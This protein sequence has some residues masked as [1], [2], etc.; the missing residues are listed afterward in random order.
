VLFGP[1]GYLYAGTGDG[2]SGNDP[3]AN[4]QNINVL[5]GKIIRLDIN[6]PVGQV[7]AYNIPPTNPY[8]G[9]TPGADEIFAIG[10]RNPYRFSFDRG[11][12]NQ[13]WVGDVGQDAV[14]E[15]DI[16][17]VGGNYGWRVYEGNQCTGIEPTNCI[18]SNYLPPVLTYA[19]AG[20]RCSV[21]GG[22]VYRGTLKTFADGTYIHSDFCS[23]EIFTWINNTH[24]MRLD[25]PRLASSFGED[26]RGEIYMTGL[27]GTNPPTGTVEKVVRVR[28]NSDF[29]GDLRTDVSVYRPS[30]GNWYITNSNN[31]SVRIQSFGL[32]GDI[33]ANEDV[34]GDLITDIGV[35]RPSTSLWY[36]YRSLDNTIS[37]VPFGISGD[38]PTIADFD[39]DTM[40]D[41]AVF[42][43]STGAW[44]VRRTT[45]PNNLLFAQFGTNGDI[46]VPADYDG[47]G[48]N[49][50]A[51]FRPATGDWYSYL[52]ASGNVSF[53]H[54]GL[55][56][57]IP[58]PADFDADGR[59]DL[60][61][62]RPS[63]GVWYVLRSLTGSTVFFQWGLDGDVPVVGDYDGDGTDDFAVFRPS[64]GLWYRVNSSN[65]AT[66]FTPF[67]L[68]GDL[69]APR[70]DAP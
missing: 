12:T 54:W 53:T 19:N 24:T 31:Q 69:P 41:L 40:A 34:D 59:A 49:D 32:S 66:F 55:N 38:I 61:V 14:E 9:A 3:Q 11:G 35:F 56:G 70:Y 64:N 43:P 48:R 28:S 46:P 57:D 10:M 17:T 15:V 65:G 6:T 1:D 2:G 20:A 25:T 50:F 58:I 39:G 33:P 7:P 45:N 68:N 18:P 52:S 63:N 23:G 26:E 62:F 13:L 27:G 21:T 22:N 29:D 5:L 60:V 67:G 30:E 4:A 16:V 42:R 51:V 36:H 47:D 8:A 44:W 37:V